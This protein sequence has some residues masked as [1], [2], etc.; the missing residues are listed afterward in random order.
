MVNQKL[1]FI[2]VAICFGYITTLAGLVSASTLFLMMLSTVTVNAVFYTV[3]QQILLQQTCSSL[4]VLLETINS[5]YV[6]DMY[7]HC[8]IHGASTV[9]LPV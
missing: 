8:I 9:H 3:S 6:N 1:S 4:P 5:K 2:T 7:L